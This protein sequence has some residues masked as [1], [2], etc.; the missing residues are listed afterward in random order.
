MI[1]VVTGSHS[2]GFDR[3]VML[4]D[5]AGARMDLDAVAQIGASRYVPKHLSWFRFCSEAEYY[6]HLEAASQVITHGGYSVVEALDRGKPVV[7]VPRR[8]DA[9]EALDDHQVAFVEWL[10]A[11]NLVEVAETEEDLARALGAGG[12]P[13][14]RGTIASR[15]QELQAFLQEAVDA[16]SRG[17]AGDR[18]HDAPS[19]RGGAIG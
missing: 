12:P 1:F 13:R 4:A 11:R 6:R 10:R 16:L 14:P 19:A 7:A 15:R 8:R 2:V 18:I 5:R 3:L 9:G 17:R